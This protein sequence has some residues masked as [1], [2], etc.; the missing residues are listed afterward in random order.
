MIFYLVISFQYKITDAINEIRI[1]FDADRLLEL[2]GAFVEFA[3]L[4]KPVVVSGKLVL[5]SVV[6]AGG[7]LVI[8][9][10]A[11]ELLVGDVVKF[12]KFEVLVE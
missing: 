1:N 3:D 2:L 8:F 7:K 10:R 12:G 6:L 5:T 11:V 4:I 9:F